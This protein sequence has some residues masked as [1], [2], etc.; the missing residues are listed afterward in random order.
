MMIDEEFLLLPLYS[1]KEDDYDS[2]WEN[3]FERTF[4]IKKGKFDE[5]QIEEFRDYMIR[6][7][8]PHCY[9]NDIVGY[10]VLYVHDRDIMIRYYLNGDQRKI[11]NHHCFDAEYRKIHLLRLKSY[12]Q[13]N[14]V[15]ITK[16]DNNTIRNSFFKL[17]DILEKDCKEWKIY[18]NKEVYIKKIKCFDFEQ[19][20]NY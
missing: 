20:W 17:L 10:A 9:F 8:Y 16:Y 15:F 2:E 4:N 14:A 13:G 7:I 19:Y 1:H 12:S 18:F 5:D 6:S 3:K 11:Y